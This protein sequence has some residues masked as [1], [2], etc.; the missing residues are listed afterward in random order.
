MKIK[1]DAKEGRV[2]SQ[3]ICSMVHVT[4]PPLPLPPP[5][6]NIAPAWLKVP[7]H[8]FLIG[9][10]PRVRSSCSVFATDLTLGPVLWVCDSRQD[11]VLGKP[12]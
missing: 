10:M 6:P 8:V 7:A 12:G 1:K 2:G 5:A 3:V 4:L 11:R 9:T